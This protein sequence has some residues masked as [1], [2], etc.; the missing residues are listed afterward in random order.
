MVLDIWAERACP[1]NFDKWICNAPSEFRME[2]QQQMSARRSQ[3]S[4]QSMYDRR[5]QWFKKA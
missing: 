3:V 2:L 4:W 5:S 1:K